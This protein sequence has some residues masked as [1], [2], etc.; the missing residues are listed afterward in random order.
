PRSGRLRHFQQQPEQPDGLAGNLVRALWQGPDGAIWVGSHGGLNRIDIDAGGV[1]H[2]HQP[3]SVALQGQALPVVFSLSGDSGNDI[4]MGTDR[5]LLRYTP[6]TGA[7]HSYVLTDGLQDLEFN[8]G[9][10]AALGDGRL[11][12]GGVSGV[13]VFDPARIIDSTLQPPLRLLSVQVGGRGD[14]R[15]SPAWHVGRI[16]L[17]E[18]GGLLRLRVG[19][20]DYLGN[21][22]VRY[23]YR[24]D[25][26]D[27]DWVD[28]DNRAEITYTLLPAGHYLLRVQSTNHDGVWNPQ[29]MKLPVNVTPPPWRHPLALLAYALLALALCAWL[30]FSW[31]QRRRLEQD[32]FAQIRD[33]EERLKLAL[34]ASGEQF[35]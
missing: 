31:R 23:R 35:W 1:P 14:L 11:A 27:Q 32:Y 34:W 24:I 26:L 2:F 30:V 25:G 21:A 13:N 33:R 18:S 28:N 9:A 6:R 17:P 10:A 7:L 16:R 5:G 12:F 8:G 3:L 4:W 15:A 29:E 20:L 19:A 22:Q